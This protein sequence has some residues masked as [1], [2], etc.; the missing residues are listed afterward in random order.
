MAQEKYEKALKGPLKRKAIA[1]DRSE[2]MQR[3][4]PGHPSIRALSGIYDPDG[5]WI[6]RGPDSPQKAIYIEI[7]HYSI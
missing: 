7:Q 1:L 5:K 2:Y 6:P 3:G 4:V